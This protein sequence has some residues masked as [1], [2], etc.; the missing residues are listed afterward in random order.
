VCECCEEFDIEI[1]IHGPLQ[2]RRVMAKVSSAVKDKRLKY[3]S[4]ESDRV[5]VEQKPFPDV[6]LK[7]SLPDVICYYFECGKCGNMY[8]LIV[9]TY[10]GGG[11]KWSALGPIGS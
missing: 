7:G 3:N 9:E 6:D 4:F 10:H 1:P 2:L 5:L 8:E 11:G